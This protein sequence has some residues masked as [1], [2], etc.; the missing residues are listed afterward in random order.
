MPT[1]Y[2]LCEYVHTHLPISEPN[3]LADAYERIAEDIHIHT[4]NMLYTYQRKENPPIT[5]SRC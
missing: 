1:S 3:R 4:H 5:S 2:I